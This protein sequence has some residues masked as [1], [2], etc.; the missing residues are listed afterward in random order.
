M[1][2][3]KGLNSPVSCL[4]QWQYS[5]AMGNGRSGK[6]SETALVYFPKFQ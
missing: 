4:Q 3:K 2:Q 6:C 5:I 1:A